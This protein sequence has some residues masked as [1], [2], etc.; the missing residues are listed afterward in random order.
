[1]A[2]DTVIQTDTPIA[3]DPLTELLRGGARKVDR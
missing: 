2:K 1:M 3:T